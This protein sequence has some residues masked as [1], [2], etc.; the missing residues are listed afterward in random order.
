MATI[1]I[2][3]GTFD[4]VTLGHQDLI[5]R[6]A[7]IFTR[8]I[9]AVAENVHKKPIFNLQQRIDMLNNA[10]RSV[11]NV[12]VK[13][14]SNLLVDFARQHDANIIVRGVR[15]VTD[16]EY[17]LQLASM[18]RNLAPHLE[19]IFLTPAQEFSYIS[20]SMVKEVAQLGGDVSKFVN[21]EIVAA[22]KG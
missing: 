12:E 13:G 4:P 3:P 7:K 17:E 14:F 16:F 22:L 15:V 9:V 19:T 6:A 21:A 20:S 10:M 8:V 2:F 1:A 11:T 18:N 5:A